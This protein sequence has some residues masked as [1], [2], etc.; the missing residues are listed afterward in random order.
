MIG[1]TPMQQLRDQK[2]DGKI[3]IA[4]LEKANKKKIKIGDEYHIDK[5]MNHEF[6]D[7][8]EKLD[9]E[10]EEDVRKDAKEQRRKR[11]EERKARKAKGENVDTIKNA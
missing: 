7:F 2:E 11:K 4:K 10:V 6:D 5:F 9:R 3:D 1:R 8:T